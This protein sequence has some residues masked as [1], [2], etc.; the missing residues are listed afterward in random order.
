VGGELWLMTQCPFPTSLKRFEVS[1][2]GGGTLAYGS[3]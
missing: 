1:Q 3:M 2:G